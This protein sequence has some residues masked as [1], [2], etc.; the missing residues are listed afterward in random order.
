MII[1]SVVVSIFA[2][3]T[4]IIIIIVSNERDRLGRISELFFMKNV[5]S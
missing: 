4:I 5:G 3:I 1:V 2:V